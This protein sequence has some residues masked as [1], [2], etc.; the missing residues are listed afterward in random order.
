MLHRDA[1]FAKVNTDEQQQLAAAFEIQS[2]PTL[3]IF[4]D[5]I[6]VYAQPGALPA[7]GARRDHPAREGARHGRRAAADR[8]RT[9]RTG[10]AGEEA[11]SSRGA[12]ARGRRT[13]AGGRGVSRASWWRAPRTG[14][15]LDRLLAAR[16]P[17]ASR[18]RVAGW[19]RAGRARI[20]GEVV[21][22]AAALAAPGQRVELRSRSAR[23]TR[24]RRSTTCSRWSPCARR[25]LARD[26][27]AGGRTVSPGRKRDQAHAADGAR[28]APGARHRAGRAVAAAPARP[29]D[30]GAR[31]RGALRRVQRRLVRAFA[32]GG[33]ERRYQARVRGDASRHFPVSSPVL[34]LR[35]SILRCG[36]RPPRFR[37]DPAG[38]TA[39]TRARLVHAGKRRERAR[40][41]AGHRA[42][43]SAARAPRAP[44]SRRS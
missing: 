29:R 40:A 38:V 36:H 24:T 27:E 37:V 5:Q 7:A 6:C 39:R 19:I 22:R 32:A 10:P 9:R 25:R 33:I 12:P 43:A 26:R 15:R 16:L 2:I 8:G 4:R 13:P 28:I 17:F 44:R 20:D 41:R 34:E 42:P 23:A 1:V 31:A 35:G 11:P 30:L 3:A 14:E 21:A 18:T